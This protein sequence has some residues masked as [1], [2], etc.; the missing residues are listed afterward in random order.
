MQYI[1]FLAPGF[2]AA[3]TLPV[4]YEKYDD[5]VDNFIYN[6]S[7]HLQKNFKKLDKNFLRRIPTGRFR[8]RKY[9]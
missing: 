5:K 1:F 2:V 8:G 4:L 7:G 9:D 6:F 3:H